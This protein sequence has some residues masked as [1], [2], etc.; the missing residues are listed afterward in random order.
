MLGNTAYALR[1]RVRV[2]A[3]RGVSTWCVRVRSACLSVYRHLCIAH[4]CLPVCRCLL[5][6]VH[7]MCVSVSGH[8]HVL[9]I[10]VCAFRSL[11]LNVS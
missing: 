1:V 5:S 6:D 7:Q 3:L 2:R 4:A 9:Y 10:I 11:S 8:T